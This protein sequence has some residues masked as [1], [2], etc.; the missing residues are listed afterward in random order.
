MSPPKKASGVDDED[1]IWFLLKEDMMSPDYTQK[2]LSLSTIRS[3]GITLQRFLEVTGTEGSPSKFAFYMHS[4][5]MA[6]AVRLLTDEAIYATHHLYCLNDAI[7]LIIIRPLE[8]DSPNTSRAPSYQL[9]FAE[10]RVTSGE[11]KVPD[12]PLQKKGRQV[13]GGLDVASGQNLS[14]MEDED[15]VIVLIEEDEYQTYSKDYLL[16]KDMK[17]MQS[18]SFPLTCPRVDLSSN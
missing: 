2:P 17:R 9:S 14:E 15:K 3:Q 4:E 11:R 16:G 8:E 10:R 13:S 5:S 12:V 6:A 18:V 7:V 1:Q